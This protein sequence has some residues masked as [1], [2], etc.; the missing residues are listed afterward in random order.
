MSISTTEVT[1]T[2]E[3]L[4]AARTIVYHALGDLVS[5]ACE[6]EGAVSDQIAEFTRLAEALGGWPYDGTVWPCLVRSR[7]PVGALV[8]G[9]VIRL[10]RLAELVL[11]DVEDVKGGTYMDNPDGRGSTTAARRARLVLEALGEAPA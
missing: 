6:R 4:E 11:L 8:L 10:R 9:H 2:G 3:A 5:F 7:R 1:L